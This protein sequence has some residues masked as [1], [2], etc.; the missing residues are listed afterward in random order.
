MCAARA[1]RGERTA[2]PLPVNYHE[3]TRRHKSLRT[4]ADKRLAQREKYY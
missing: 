2:A 3:K 1:G 4:N